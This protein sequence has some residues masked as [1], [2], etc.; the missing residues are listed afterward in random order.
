MARK[1]R[2]RV[3]KEIVLR[4]KMFVPGEVQVWAELVWDASAD[5]SPRSLRLCLASHYGLAPDSLL[6]ALFQPETHGW[7]EIS[8]WNQR[9]SKKKKRKRT[10]SLLAAPFHLKD[11][12]TIAVKN[13]LLDAQR[14]FFVPEDSRCRQRRKEQ[15]ETKTGVQTGQKKKNQAKSRRPEVGLS[16]SVG[17]FR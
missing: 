7:E 14:D 10:E 6:L 3:Q 16:I 4:V 9:V 17:E 8:L 1:G 15:T 2:D 5:P 11:G 13:L 12:D